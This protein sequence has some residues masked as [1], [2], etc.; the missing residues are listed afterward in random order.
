MIDE[1]YVRVIAASDGWFGRYGKGHNRYNS[2]RELS[3][4]DPLF[5]MR[6][7][8]QPASLMTA[9]HQPKLMSPIS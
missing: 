4:R 9:S 3:L 2:M 5:R 6:S 1:C 8:T 7:A